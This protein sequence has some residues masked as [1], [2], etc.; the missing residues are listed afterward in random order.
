MSAA[1]ETSLLSGRFE[2]IEESTYGETPSNPSWNRLSD[3]V[4][5]WTGSQDVQREALNVLGDHN[6]IDH[7]SGAEDASVDVS[8]YLQN[9]FVD[10]SGNLQDASAYG[11][12]RQ[13]D[14]TPHNSHTLM[15]RKE[16]VDDSD[17]A[18]RR[19]YFIARG[20]RI[21][22]VD[23]T[24]DP[25]ESVPILVE[26][27]YQCRYNSFRIDQPSSSTTLDIVSTSANDTMDITIEDEGANTTETIS[28]NGT[29]TVTTSSNFGDI[30][31]VE[32]ASA[33]EGDVTVTDG[34]GNTLVTLYG[35]NSYAEDGASLDGDLGVPALGSGSHS[36]SIGTSYEH[37]IGDVFN[38]PASTSFQVNSD[39]IDFHGTG[40]SISNTVEKNAVAGSR[41]QT[42]DMGNQTVEFNAD[43][44]GAGV[45]H[46][47]IKD[48]L[49]GLEEN[50]EWIPE[51]G[52]SKQV[53]FTNAELTDLGDTPGDEPDQARAVVSNTFSAQGITLSG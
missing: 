46:A 18:L 35:G 16:K 29:T 8:Y 41:H 21:E 34:S 48:H 27:T 47:S 2:W 31:A 38:K 12:E 45:S 37:V 23:V 32:L 25:S 22:S 3:A 14:G 42:I 36:S 24:L 7:P 33:A 53:T 49:Q 19:V 52:G 11:I 43:V 17:N 39:D 20:G 44:S 13:G 26:L 50:I 30:D 51:S 1:P 40:F 6:P 4:A 9:W 28:L 15:Q 5:G 10:S